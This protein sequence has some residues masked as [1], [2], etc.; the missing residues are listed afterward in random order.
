MFTIT[1]SPFARAFAAAALLG[2]LAVATPSFAAPNPADVDATASSPKATPVAA[3]GSGKGHSP[4][5]M[6]ASVEN[7][8][9]TLHEKL[10]ITADQESN[11]NDFAQ[12]M[13][14]NE[15]SM[16]TA[17]QA[18]HQNASTM[19]AVDDLS[20]YQK[21]A[22]SHADGLAKLVSAFQPVYDAMSDDQKKNAD[23]VFGQFEGH[24]G[25]SKASAKGGSGPKKGSSS[26]MGSDGGSAGSSSDTAE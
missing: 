8:I 12:A 22:Q 1:S 16:S 2:S 20:S 14:D 5:E 19:S 10:G 3:S 25:M 11:W 6:A 9:K 26:G 24:R 15:A 23:N 7:R 21:I 17:I 18:R 13:R 4:A